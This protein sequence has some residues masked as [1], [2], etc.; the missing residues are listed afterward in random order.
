M[1]NFFSAALNPD[2]ETSGIIGMYGTLYI[3]SLFNFLYRS[4]GP[5]SEALKAKGRRWSPSS[6]YSR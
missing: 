3:N 5:Y 4:S 6:N 1:K 2:L